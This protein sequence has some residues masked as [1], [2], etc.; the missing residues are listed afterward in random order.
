M[1][2]CATA[3]FALSHHVDAYV[4][5]IETRFLNI[6]AELGWPMTFL[7]QPRRHESGKAVAIRFAVGRSELAT[8][9]AHFAQAPP[10]AIE[11]PAWLS[12]TPIDPLC[13]AVIDEIIAIEDEEL[14]NEALAECVRLAARDAIS[15][16]GHASSALF[17]LPARGNA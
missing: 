9:R 11:I 15:R 3:E 4:A 6:F 13:F 17:Q 12:S 7:G 5:C 16:C 1:L 10:S 8:T 14:R 2:L